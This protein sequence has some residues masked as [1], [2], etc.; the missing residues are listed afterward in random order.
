MHGEEPYISRTDYELNELCDRWM[1]Y[2]SWW[3]ISLKW[4]DMYMRKRYDMI[5]R[6]INEVDIVVY[7]SACFKIQ[8]ISEAYALNAPNCMNSDSPRSSHKH[9]SM[10]VR[11]W[12]G[13]YNETD[14]NNIINMKRPILEAVIKRI[15]P[16]NISI[17]GI[18][19]SR[20]RN[21]LLYYI[22]NDD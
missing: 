9:M 8:N 2:Y 11:S 19:V 17:V 21:F 20:I 5:N 4:D 6:M 18:I 10:M 7:P 13:C 1:I 16:S 12:L 3:N 14:I 22:S 15:S